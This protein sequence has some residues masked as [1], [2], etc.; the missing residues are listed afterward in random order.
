MNNEQR[1]IYIT[2]PRTEQCVENGVSVLV[3]NSVLIPTKP[4]IQ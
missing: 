4:H 3:A 1:I 2:H